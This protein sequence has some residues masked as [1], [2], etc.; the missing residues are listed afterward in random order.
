MLESNDGTKP[1]PIK[2]VIKSVLPNV[3]NLAQLENPETQKCIKNYL[4]RRK[5]QMEMLKKRG[6]RKRRSGETYHIR[7]HR[8]I[9]TNGEDQLNKM[10][11]SISKDQYLT[12]NFTYMPLFFGTVAPAEGQLLVAG[13]RHNASAEEKFMLEKILSIKPETA[14]IPTTT[15]VPTNVPNLVPPLTPPTNLTHPEIKNNFNLDLNSPEVKKTL[16]DIMHRQQH[17]ESYEVSYIKCS[18]RDFKTFKLGNHQARKTSSKRNQ[19]SST[20]TTKSG[21]ASNPTNCNS[22][23]SECCKC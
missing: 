9:N 5:R 1:Y 12:S 20:T 3:K 14:L 19:P 2:F 18:P 11:D 16:M 21:S 15:N 23:D 7:G 4:E 6:K 13:I 10:I 17:A 8:N 22:T